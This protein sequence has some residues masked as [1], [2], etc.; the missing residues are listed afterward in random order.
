M[1]CNTFDGLT[2]LLAASPSRRTALGVLLG[3]GLA[4]KLGAAEAKKDRTKKRQGGRKATGGADVSAQADCLSPGRG[5]AISRC[6]YTG[7]DFSGQDLSSS[8]MVGTIFR[9]ATLVGTDLSS[10][11]AKNAVF[12]GADLICADLRSANLGGAD[13]RGADLTGATLKSSSGC[14]TALFNT[15]TTFCATTM[16]NGAVRND[17][18]PGGIPAA[19]CCSADDECGTCLA[20]VGGACQAAPDR[21]VACDGSPLVPSVSDMCTIHA[22]TGV[23]F[24]GA[25]NCGAGSYDAPAN[26]CRCDAEGEEFCRTHDCRECSVREICLSASGGSSTTTACVG[27]PPS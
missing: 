16:C 27:C 26:A 9:D 18:C 1:D 5:S 7:E 15:A 20:C 23:C 12:A 10:S 17:D 21:S 14:A 22:G 6:D 13:F 11:G 4:G 19:V 25:C 3:A 24:G 2:K 8:Q